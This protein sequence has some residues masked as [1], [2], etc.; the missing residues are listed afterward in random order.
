MIQRNAPAKDRYIHN[1][2]LRAGLV[3]ET[4]HYKYSSATDY[5][6]DINGLLRLEH[7]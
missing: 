1:N 2:P 7:V 3:N 4:R 6:T 5:C